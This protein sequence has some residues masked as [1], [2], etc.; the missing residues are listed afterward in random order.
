AVFLQEVT[1][2][3]GIERLLRH[4]YLFVI[5][6]DCRLINH[7]IHGKARKKG[8]SWF[9]PCSSVYSVVKKNALVLNEL[10]R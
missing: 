10:P 8:A 1:Y 4:F 5:I 7:G 3:G 2:Y 6:I 9:L